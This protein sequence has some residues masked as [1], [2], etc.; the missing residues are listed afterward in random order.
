MD[1]EGGAGAAGVGHDHRVAAVEHVLE[2]RILLAGSEELGVAVLVRGHHGA[3]VAGVVE[4]RRQRFRSLRAAGRRDEV[5]DRDADA[6]GHR[7]VDGVAVGAVVGRLPRVGA[8]T[9]RPL[10]V[11][12]RRIAAIRRASGAGDEDCCQGH[13]QGRPVE[14]LSGSHLAAPLASYLLCPG[15]GRPAGGANPPARVRPAA[16]RR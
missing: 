7:D 8:E 1:A 4:D 11:R 6:V 14:V 5:V 12:R 16:G 3:R 9:A 15:C 10:A 13:A 2:N